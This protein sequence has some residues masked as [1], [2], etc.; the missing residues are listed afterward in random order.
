[1][2][3]TFEE[4]NATSTSVHHFQY[5]YSLPGRYYSDPAIFN[6][7]IDMLTRNQWLLVG[8]TSQLKTPGDFFIFQIGSY[9]LLITAGKDGNI[10]A[11]HNVCRHR[12]SI[13][14]D[15]P[16]GNQKSFTCPY[17][18]WTYEADG[19]LRQPRHMPEDFDVSENGLVRVKCEIFEGMVFLNLAA[20]PATDFQTFVG[21]FKRFLEPYKINST[22]IAVH[23]SYATMANWKLVTENF[24]ECYHCQPAHKTYSRVHDMLKHLALGSGTS[25][26]DSHSMAQF[27]P[28]LRNWEEKVQ[29]MNLPTGFWSADQESNYFSSAGRLPIGGDAKTE[30]AD[31]QPVAP[32]LGDLQAYDGGQSA[33]FLNPVSAIL[34][35]SDYALMVFYRPIAPRE[36]VVEAMWLVNDNA[37]VNLD[38]YETNILHFWHT[39][40]TEDKKI[41]EDN[42]L[43]IDSP[44][45][46]PGRYSNQE[47]RLADFGIH[48]I[49]AIENGQT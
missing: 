49:A 47:G 48:Y 43:G 31:G 40:L 15:M 29:K 3:D 23:K 1:M 45:Y 14:C 17:H 32:L 34:C 2:S 22:K 39:T 21:P 27:E 16:A 25:V 18:A 5:G 12:G 46:I 8:H 4:R 6:L 44:A 35:N 28:T 20:E 13:I 7:D 11:M 33:C 24:L 42:Q 38:Y 30:S 19:T 26:Q 36:T 37:K 41:T 9:N 10:R